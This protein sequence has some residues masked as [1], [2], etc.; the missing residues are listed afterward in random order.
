MCFRPRQSGLRGEL[1]L[2][3]ARVPWHWVRP[4]GSQARRAS[5]QTRARREVESRSQLLASQPVLH[6]LNI[7]NGRSDGILTAGDFCPQ[8]GQGSGRTLAVHVPLGVLGAV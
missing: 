8:E 6:W 2:L 5:P 4:L 3:E 1:L 7:I